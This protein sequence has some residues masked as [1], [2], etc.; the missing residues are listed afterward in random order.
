MVPR[1]LLPAAYPYYLVA[2]GW[3]VCPALATDMDVFVLVG[4]NADLQTVRQEILDHLKTEAFDHTEQDETREFQGYEGLV[5]IG[6][7]ATVDL[8]PSTVIHIM[9]ANTT[10][11]ED[12]LGSFDLSTCMV[13]I[14][15]SGQVVK[16]D[17][18]TPPTMLPTVLKDTPSTPARRA[19]YIERFNLKENAIGI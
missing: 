4:P 17:Y 10:R 7:V 14:T 11:Y 8:F 9:V 15:E 2:G 3:A 5:G 16:G 13:G 6:K 1:N 18:W 19:K 12:V